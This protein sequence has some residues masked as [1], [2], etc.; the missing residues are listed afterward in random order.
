MY[1]NPYL[2]FYPPPPHPPPPK[3]LTLPPD[4]RHVLSFREFYQKHFNTHRNF[5]QF[6]LDPKPSSLWRIE[7]CNF[8][9]WNQP[10]YKYPYEYNE[11]REE[12]EEP[13]DEKNELYEEYVEDYEENEGKEEKMQFVLS[14]E[15]IAM[16]RFSEL[17]RLKLKENGKIE[18]SSSPSTTYVTSEPNPAE[19]QPPNLSAKEAREF[20]G[21]SY[22][23]IK[24]MEATLNNIYIKSY[25]IKR[26]QNN[27]IENNEE[28]NVV[29]YWPV[30]PLKF[31][32]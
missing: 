2:H 31:T 16:F 15:A 9:W 14:D 18:N 23:T 1:S 6:A 3:N 8:N 11:P 24:V 13:Y 27:N 22:S 10:F 17:R 12:E 26:D 5:F 20:Y 30:L 21:D 28:E 29:V 25:E 4:P 32:F 7:S 19:L